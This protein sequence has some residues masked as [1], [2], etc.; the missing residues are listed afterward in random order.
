ML[1]LELEQ[2]KRDDVGWVIMIVPQKATGDDNKVE[3]FLVYHG[4]N[5]NL[6]LMLI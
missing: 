3:V 2:S 1:W 6:W 5:P 4:L